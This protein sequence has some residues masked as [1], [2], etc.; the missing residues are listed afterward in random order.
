MRN[1]IAQLVCSGVIII[2]KSKPQGGW[3]HDGPGADQSYQA[4]KLLQVNWGGIQTRHGVRNYMWKVLVTSFQSNHSIELMSFTNVNLSTSAAATFNSISDGSMVQ[5]VVRAFTI[6]GLHSDLTSDGFIIDTSAP[7]AGKAYD[8]NQTGVD[9]KYA[10][11]RATFSANWD[12]FT[13][14]HSH[15]A[16]YDMA[17]QRQKK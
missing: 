14:P 2:D 8:G 13:D 12:R 5:F 9:M 3:I 11:W 4:S 7:V 10:K 16:R 6:A 1:N 17:V 15:I